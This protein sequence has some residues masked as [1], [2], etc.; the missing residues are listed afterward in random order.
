D[1][2]LP[3]KYPWETKGL[4]FFAFKPFYLGCADAE[5]YRVQHRPV[6][7]ADP[8]LL[9]G[10]A[11]VSHD[12]LAVLVVTAFAGHAEEQPPA[13]PGPQA[14]GRT[15]AQG[16]HAGK[17]PETTRF[18]PVPVQDDTGRPWGSVTVATTS[19]APSPSISQTSGPTPTGST[20]MCDVS[21]GRSRTTRSFS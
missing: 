14:A 5:P 2:T 11:V 8:E 17:Q 13:A 7:V 9:P 12:E 3:Y 4:K 1:S 18:L 20:R 15:T 21:Y 16:G 6:V 19:L 10:P